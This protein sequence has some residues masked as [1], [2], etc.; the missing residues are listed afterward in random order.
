VT[1]FLLLYNPGLADSSIKQSMLRRIAG[2]GLGYEN[3]KD[4]YQR[5]GR[6][7][8]VCILTRP[9]LLSHSSAPRVTNTMRIVS[10]FVKHFK[11]ISRDSAT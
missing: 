11:E 6:K 3:L 9:P 1:P 8:P 2:S 7:G 10:A 4:L 5:F